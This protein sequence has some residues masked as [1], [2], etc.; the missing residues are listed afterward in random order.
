MNTPPCPYCQRADMTEPFFKI[1]NV[2][3]EWICYHCGLT[4]NLSS[5]TENKSP[6]DIR[7]DLQAKRIERDSAD[8]VLMATGRL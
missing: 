2:L 7:V 4:W 5:H 6:L 1:S 3:I 8:L